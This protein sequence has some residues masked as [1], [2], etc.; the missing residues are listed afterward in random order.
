[1][2]KKIFLYFI[3]AFISTVINLFIQRLVISLNDENQFLFL[4]IFLGTL[5]GL[6]TKFYLDKNFIFLESAKKIK[7]NSRLFALYTL[8]GL[9]STLIFWIIES[10]FWFTWKNDLMR[11]L[12][13]ILGL[14]IGYSIKYNLDKNF[15]FNK[16]IN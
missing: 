13:A 3:F 10:I 7:N 15:V 5:F 11:E 1:M 2:N 12:G 4:A 9:V 8:M 16:R 6:I 14:T